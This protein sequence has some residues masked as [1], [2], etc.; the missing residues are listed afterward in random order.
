M[1]YQ[2]HWVLSTG[3]TDPTHVNT[4]AAAIL[5]HADVSQVD[6]DINVPELNMVSW[7]IG[8]D[9]LVTTGYDDNDWL[10]FIAQQLLEHGYI[11]TSIVGFS[12]T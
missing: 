2:A 7:R 3:Y 4:V 11:M 1:A 9:P 8:F 5:A 12:L 6:V 10:I